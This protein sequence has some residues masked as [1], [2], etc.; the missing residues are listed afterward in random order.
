M[1]EKEMEERRRDQRR[2]MKRGRKGKGEKKD[3]PV[4][5]GSEE[6]DSSFVSDFQT[7]SLPHQIV[8]HVVQLLR[9]HHERIIA[10]KLVHKPHQVENLRRCESEESILT[11]SDLEC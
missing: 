9:A 3:R 6:D 11:E 10:E 4:L 7:I 8:L 5:S 1:C 2:S